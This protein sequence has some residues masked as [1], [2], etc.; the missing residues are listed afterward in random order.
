L[1]NT[2]SLEK[3]YAI[4]LDEKIKMRINDRIGGKKP[5]K[6]VKSSLQKNNDIVKSILEMM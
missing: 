5:T 1:S 4:T 3:L 6:C 2:Y